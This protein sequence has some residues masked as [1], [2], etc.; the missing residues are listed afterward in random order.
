MVFLNIFESK[1]KLEYEVIGHNI[2]RKLELDE[3][4]RG[5]YKKTEV[6][7]S[8]DDNIISQYHH[9]VVELRNEGDF[10]EE[11]LFFDIDFGN[12]SIKVL[13]VLSKTTKPEEQEIKASL[14]YD[15]T[16]NWS[17]KGQWQTIV[18]RSNNQ[19]ERVYRYDYQIDIFAI[20]VM[21]KY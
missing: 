13:D 14:R 16:D 15:F 7:F 6:D 10:I 17:I 5:N 9:T 19:D 8:V 21:Y 11:D 3:V 4:I 1:A 18:A 12:S 20:G 2:L